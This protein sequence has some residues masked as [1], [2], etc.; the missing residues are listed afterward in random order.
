MISVATPHPGY[1]VAMLAKLVVRSLLIGTL[2][3]AGCAGA[4][5]LTGEPS[6]TEA[7]TV[8]SQPPPGPTVIADA[9]GDG[10]LRPGDRVRCRWKGGDTEYAGH[11]AE[12]RD[13]QVFIKY[14][15][16]DEELTSPSLCRKDA[17]PGHTLASFPVGARVRCQWKGQPTEYA[18]TVAAVEGDRLFVKYDDG[19]EE[20]TVPS[21]CRPE[22]AAAT[23][24]GATVFDIISSSNPGG[25]NAYRGQ[26]AMKKSGD[27]FELRWTIDR[28]PAYSG[29]GIEEGSELGVGWGTGNGHGIVVYRIQGGTL[30][31]R[32][33]S[34]GTQGQIGTEDLR[35]P[36]GLNGTYTIVASQSPIGGKPYTGTVTIQPTGDTYSLRWQL[37]NESY[38]GVGI[39]RGNAL[40][41]GWGTGNDAGIVVY[42]RRGSDLDGVW[43]TPGGTQLGTEVLK[44]R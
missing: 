2:A 26:L 9:P 40:F 15:D 23:V 28:T 41:V 16:G 32:W 43:A 42:T 36:P 27:V 21:L 12:A 24:D 35:G 10:S 34:P 17:G 8:A 31:G 20:R 3:L 1:D 5:P 44:K 22:S 33:A 18:G 19:D 39:K 4:R 25:G 29:L 7:A 13:G 38:N 14:D 11:V 30:R 37:P 6:P